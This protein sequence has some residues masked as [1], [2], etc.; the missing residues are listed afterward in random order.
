MLK[1]EFIKEKFSERNYELLETEYKNGSTKMK[2]KCLKHPDRDELSMTY[3]NLQQG[4]GCPYCSPK[5]PKDI[6]EIIME[7]EK[8]GYKLLTTNYINSQQKLQYICSKHPDKEL[9][10]RYSQLNQGQGCVYCGYV[11]TAHK[12]T[13]T[14]DFVKKTFE[15]RGYQLLSDKYIGSQHELEYFCPK[16]PNK[17]LSIKFVDFKRGHGCWYCGHETTNLKQKLSLEVVK[18]AFE[19]RGYQLLS[20]EYINSQEKLKYICPK[21][22]EQ[23]IA[24]S[25]LKQGHGCP[26]CGGIGKPNIEDIKNKMKKRNYELLEEEYINSNTPMRYR[27]PFHPNKILFITYEG[28]RQG[29]GCIYCRNE[30]RKGETSANWKGGVTSLNA[31][32]RSQIE[33]WKYIQFVKTNNQ[34]VFT[35]EKR[36]VVVHHLEPFYIIRNNI[37]KELNLP[38]QT[39]GK[40]DFKELE[41]I[42][43]KF[44]DHHNNMDGVVLRKDIHRFFHNLYTN[45]CTPADFEAFTLR[46]K[47]GEFVGI[48]DGNN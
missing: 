48:F 4:K 32:L 44:L 47:S 46:W 42:K 12:K 19:D 28:V 40:Y 3:S 34:C 25:D 8:R 31:Y 18:K 36:N 20:E 39:I 23:F 27:C 2:Y 37:L 9:F 11:K 5:H 33:D 30:K 35:K 15:D 41:L 1:Y 10:I 16:H 38:I 43:T 29:H 6:K 26:Y 17:K 24:Y 21:H 22:N 14:F 13:F 45:N 7:F